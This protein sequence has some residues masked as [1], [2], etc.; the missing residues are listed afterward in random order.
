MPNIF[1]YEDYRSFLRDYY[2]EMKN[3]MPAFSYKYLAGKAG[4]ANKGFLFNILNGKK[5]LCK[6][7]IF[8]IANILKLNKQETEYFEILIALSQANTPEEQ[9]HYYERLIDL[10][11]DG[12]AGAQVIRKDQYEFYARW[13]H[14]AIR[15]VIDIKGFDGDYKN[16]AKQLHPEITIRQAK[17]SVALL[18][19]LGLI[20]KN[21]KHEYRVADKLISTGKEPPASGVLNFHLDTLDLAKQAIKE[22]P[23]PIRNISGLTLGISEEG[24]NTLCDEIRN[25]RKRILQ[26]AKN[27]RDADRVYQLNFHFFPMSA[28]TQ[29]RTSI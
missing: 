23:K 15:S 4:I 3:K 8:R 27:S 12:L 26:L 6:P 13:W 17:Q 21:S 28:I 24:Y 5:D 11:G 1:N 20:L 18:L 19:K 16:L 14:A 2:T 29:G 22:L 25:F 10:K 9:H 7:Y